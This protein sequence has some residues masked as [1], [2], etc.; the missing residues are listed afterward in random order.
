MIPDRSEDSDPLEPPPPP[1]DRLK[2]AFRKGRK[3]QPSQQEGV[4]MTSLKVQQS[5]KVPEKFLSVS[6]R[7]ARFSKQPEIPV[8]IERVRA[9]ITGFQRDLAKPPLRRSQEELANF[10]HDTM[11]KYETDK[12]QAENN[13]HNQL[14]KMTWTE[15]IK[16]KKRM[17]AQIAQAWKICESELNRCPAGEARNRYDQQRNQAELL[18]QQT[19]R[20]RSVGPESALAILNRSLDQAKAELLREMATV[21]KPSLAKK[22]AEA[23]IAYYEWALAERNIGLVETY[24]KQ[25]LSPEL[26]EKSLLAATQTR[27][28]ALKRLENLTKSSRMKK[29]RRQGKEA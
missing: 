5:T 24:D 8:P 14:N 11:A 9:Q 29:L 12:T 4:E 10:V 7:K 27:D 16:A 15:K 13:Y 28:A 20:D 22:S 18:Y 25:D 6:P 23:H 19:L 21:V 2:R 17:N 26:Y 3:R 1:L